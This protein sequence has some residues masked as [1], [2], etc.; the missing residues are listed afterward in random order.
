M[1]IANLVITICLFLNIE[2]L[3]EAD[4]CNSNRKHFQRISD[5]D[6]SFNVKKINSFFAHH[7][8]QIKQEISRYPVPHS[9]IKS[10]L[11]YYYAIL[12]EMH[13]KLLCTQFLTR[14]LVCFHGG[15]VEKA[16]LILCFHGVFITN[17]FLV[18]VK[19]NLE[20]IIR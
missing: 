19:S 14:I 8:C 1:D 9:C 6:L 17:P 20:L 7:R 2:D 12:S 4:F 3:V 13:N 18:F 10:S 15:F 11:Q 5:V 16:R